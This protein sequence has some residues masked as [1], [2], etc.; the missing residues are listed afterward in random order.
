MHFW[1][2]SK[3]RRGIRLLIGWRHS[4]DHGVTVALVFDVGEFVCQESM[5][6]HRI[7]IVFALSEENVRAI[8]ER[9]RVDGLRRTPCG[10]PCVNPDV[11]EV[12][13]ERC[14]E[15]LPLRGVEWLPTFRE[16]VGNL[17]GVDVIVDSSSASLPNR[18]DG[19]HCVPGES[20]GRNA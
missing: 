5:P 12:G 16:R 10:R 4:L 1:N 8:G 14:F 9:P 15:L 3:H 19:L 13:S 6:R 11:A 18:P 7:W 2:E 17:A 20:R